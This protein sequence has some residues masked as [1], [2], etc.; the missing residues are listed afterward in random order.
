MT[1]VA[2]TIEGEVKAI[3]TKVVEKVEELVYA[4]RVE[5]TDSEKLVLR[6]IETEFLKAQLEVNRLT[7]ILKTTQEQ[8]T[9]KI[10]ELTTKYVV[11]E[12]V[13]AFDAVEQVFKKIK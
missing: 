2:K 8:F 4:A 12:A 13:Y 6:T 11:D 3:E 1:G 9:K 10:K 7:S 5:I